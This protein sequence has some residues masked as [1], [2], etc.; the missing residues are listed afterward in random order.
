MN[1]NVRRPDHPD[2][3]LL[4][5]SLSLIFSSIAL[6]FFSHASAS[7]CHPTINWYTNTPMMDPRK[8]AKMGTKNQQSL[9]LLQTTRKNFLSYFITDRCK[10]ERSMQGLKLQEWLTMS[11]IHSC[12]W[13]KICTYVKTSGPQP[14]MAVK[15]RGPKSLAG[16][17]A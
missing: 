17:T 5:T 3:S 14:A 15:R 11:S 2:P 1:A 16:L 13:K 4:V 10:L 8:G 9:A 6:F 12:F 7:A